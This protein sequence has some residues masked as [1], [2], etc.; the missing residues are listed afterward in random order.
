MVV[1]QDWS[2]FDVLVRSDY[3]D[4]ARL[5]FDPRFPTNR[6]LDDLL[7]RHFGLHRT[8]CYLTNLFPFIK[9]GDATARIPMKDLIKAARQFTIPEIRI[10]SPRLVICLGLMTF[11]SLMRV[12]GL[13]GSPKLDEA[14]ASPFEYAGSMFHCVAHTGARGMNNRG[15]SQVEEDWQ[16]IAGIMEQTKS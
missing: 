5:G 3:Y 15:H 12:A 8:D 11:R 7:L 1:A 2:S 10:V 14:I 6:K 16:K 9:P 4:I 13:N